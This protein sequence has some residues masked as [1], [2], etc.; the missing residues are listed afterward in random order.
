MTAGKSSRTG[1]ML[2]TDV[3]LL[4]RPQTLKTSIAKELAHDGSVLLLYPRLV[5]LPVGSGP[6]ELDPIAQAVL[7]QPVIHELTTF[8][9]IQGAQGEREAG[10]NS[11]ERL[12]HQSAFPNDDGSSLGSVAGDVSQNQTMNVAASVDASTVRH[13]VHFHAAW[14]RIVPIGRGP[15]LDAPPRLRLSSPP[16][17]RLPR[18]SGPS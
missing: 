3:R 15:N 9:H 18:V 10:A 7:D 12:D 4:G 14:S 8:V 6:G 2:R 5:V 13:Q 1:A 11:L 17:L 16:A